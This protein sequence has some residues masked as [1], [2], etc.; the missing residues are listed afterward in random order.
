MPTERTGTD[1]FE[2]HHMTDTTDTDVLLAVD[3][4]TTR[5]KT[6]AFGTDG[7]ELAQTAR[8][9]EVDRPAP[10]HVEQPMEDT[11]E[12]AATTIRETLAAIPE[13]TPLGIGL[14][15]QGDGL[16]PIGADGTPARTAMLWSDSRAAPI[17]ETW[18]ETG[19]LATLVET[20]GSSPYP[21]MSLPCLAWLAEERPTEFE[22]I[23]TI[24]SCPSW[25]A[26]K[27]T[28]VRAIDH[29]EATVPYLDA[30][31][32]QYAPDVF[33]VVGLP[34][35]ES[36]LPSLSTPTD[37]VGTV[38]E[39]AAEATGLPSGLPVVSGPFD[40]PASAIGAGAVTPGDSVVTLGTSLT[41][42]TI[43]AGPRSA[44]AGIQM[45]LGIDGLWTEAIGSNA[46]TPSLEWAV[47]TLA[48]IDS[49]EALE[50]AA[51]EAPIGSDGIVY[52]PY[53][54][55]SG[56]RGPFVDPTARAQFLGLT[57]EHDT[58]HLAR[59]IYE[60]LSFAIADCVGLLP[61]SNGSVALGGGGARSALWCQLIADS[62]DRPVEVPTGSEI[63]AKG[64]AMVLGTALE[65]FPSIEGAADR[66]V[67]HDRRYQP[68]DTATDRYAE[69][70][71]AFVELREELPSIWARRDRAYQ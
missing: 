60:G 43:S 52:H 70:V 56:E 44:S 49:I 33:D 21:G 34:G 3:A 12:H 53:L 48:G 27:L 32:E 4:G 57:P 9:I 1:H 29:S 20:C 38:T 45:A 41:H 62:L 7:T 59:A 26:F 19:Q 46:G 39:T 30:T 67:S 42:Q 14:T 61:D 36:L 5:I 24:L 55:T 18:E 23:E 64:V 66:M 47:E 8:T 28:G 35:A 15:G 22:R 40:V 58:E 11:W 50:A 51:R 2:T 17:L 69:L 68:R 13:A 16:W 54:S 25:L 63:G 31:T 71:D 37:I 10:G 6:V 65:V